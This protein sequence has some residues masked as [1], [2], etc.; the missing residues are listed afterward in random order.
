ML[1]ALVILVN[2]FC[3]DIFLIATCYSFNPFSSSYDMED[4]L[5]TSIPF[6]YIDVNSFSKDMF[7]TYYQHRYCDF[8][9]G[10]ETEAKIFAKVRGWE[11]IFLLHSW[12]YAFGCAAC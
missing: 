11:V 7:A 4:I 3:Q 10:N 5:C 1:K 8:I 6:R 2:D 12:K 9:F